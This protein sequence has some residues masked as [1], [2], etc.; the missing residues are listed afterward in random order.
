MVSFLPVH[1]MMHI[2]FSFYMYQVMIQFSFSRGQKVVIAL[3]V[4]F[5]ALA[6]VLFFFF[7][8]FFALAT[9]KY[10]EIFLR[11]FITKNYYYSLALYSII[12]II[13]NIMALPLASLLTVVAG[14][15]Y[16]TLVAFSVTLTVST[17]GASLS[18]LTSRYVV[19]SI[20]QKVYAQRLEKFNKKIESDGAYFLV[21]VRLIPI[22]PFVLVN[23]LS[24]ITTI[25]LTTFIWTTFFGMIPVTLLFAS[26]GSLFKE[27][28]SVGQILSWKV[29]II[30]MLMA[31]GALFPLMIKR[32]NSMV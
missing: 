2:P 24:G 18:F 9:I 27:L 31:L 14:Y 13:D 25:R 28:I 3:F 10:Y 5:A 20:I 22:I 4:I 1:Y 21:A 11:A 6:G 12:F 7:S 15:F 29:V 32:R 19:G 23:V 30:F 26:S 17:I 8:D 16:G